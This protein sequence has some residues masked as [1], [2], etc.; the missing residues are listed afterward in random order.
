MANIIKNKE[1]KINDKVFLHTTA[2]LYR[3]SLCFDL[4]FHIDPGQWWGVSVA[5]HFLF[6]GFSFDID[7]D[8]SA[9]TNREEN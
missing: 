4:H 5:L 8:D 3:R 6:F 2:I 9:Y 1:Y 7:G